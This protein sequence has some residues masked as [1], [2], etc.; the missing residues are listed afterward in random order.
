MVMSLALLDM[1]GT[2]DA[3]ENAAFPGA[4]GFGQNANGW[5]GGRIVTVNSL[6]D[7]GPG[8]LRACAQSGSEPRVCVFAVS[9]DIVLDTPVRTGSRLYIAGQSAPGKG[10]Q[11]RLGAASKSPLLLEDVHD[12]LVRFLKLRPG[13]G[14]RSSPS[15]SG[16]TV[17]R[18]HDI[19]LDHLSVA[20][21]TDQNI[22]IHAGPGPTRDVTLA[23]SIS[24]FALDR[25][26]HPLGSHSKGALICSQEKSRGP[27][28]R[29]SLIGNLFA[30][31]RDRNPEVKANGTG[32][33]ELVGNVSYNG[34][35]AFF[36][37]YNNTGE[38]QVNAVGNVMLAG[39]STRRNQRPPGIRAKRLDPQVELAIHVR[40]NAAVTRKACGG[41][42]MRMLAE[43]VDPGILRPTPVAPLTV[44]WPE[45]RDTLAWVAARAGARSDTGPQ[46]D[47]LDVR[48]LRDLVRCTG[49]IIDDPQEVEG[50]PAIAQMTGPG[51][52]DGDGMPDIWELGRTGHDAKDASDAWEDADGDGWSNIEA[53]L[54]MRAG[55]DALSFARPVPQ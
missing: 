49:H 54:A 24:A 52:T 17:E 31:N 22:T 37:I 19:Y 10:V 1:A 13:P 27:C 38:T 14:A 6:A 4:M 25:S 28:G 48:V 43:D 39:R 51:D 42:P 18:S 7:A 46:P 9:G 12:V 26:N 2:V 15:V 34:K 8:T 45:G 20:F 29:V 55:D 33:I 5:R 53:Y 44:F 40:N 23:W 11:I 47:A 30:H 16:I 32:P 35:S 21:A 36:E 41:P 3:G 50:W